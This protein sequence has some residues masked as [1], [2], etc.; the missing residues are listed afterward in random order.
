M[1]T[2]LILACLL[3]LGVAVFAV[4]P[5]EVLVEAQG[6]R[7][8]GK[9]G[10]GGSKGGKG[11]KGGGK[12]M[13]GGKGVNSETQQAD[14]KQ[15]RDI[16]WNMAKRE[17]RPLVLA[18]KP[19]L[20][21]VNPAYYIHPEIARVSRG[22]AYFVSIAEGYRQTIPGD[23]GYKPPTKE[24]EEEAEN[25]GTADAD[26]PEDEGED[27]GEESRRSGFEQAG[28]AASGVEFQQAPGGE[29]DAPAAPAKPA[30][31]PPE[32]KLW[33][34]DLWK[35]F[36]VEKPD[37][38]ILCDYLGNEFYR[39]TTKPPVADLVSKIE[40]MPKDLEK[41]EKE[42]AKDLEDI[43]KLKEKSDTRGML[44]K[45]QTSFGRNR[46]G[47]ETTEKIVVEFET[48]LTDART[49]LAEAKAKEDTREGIRD[50]DAIR[51]LFTGTAVETE[52]NDLLAALRAK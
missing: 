48:L 12:G 10:K 13:K 3:S 26:A 5:S 15:P 9:G 33:R 32:E 28:A 27:G 40:K 14:W 51:R 41:A 52:A 35:S 45:I 31:S 46:Y 22:Q 42:L 1:T 20:E 50:A 21:I 6:G 17:K 24:E 39:W 34:H 44:R 18:F 43:L 47:Y 8:G 36:A 11:G 49:K 25:S 19:I 4:M 30:I 37:T 29:K 16:T 7:G 2:R 38:F 23:K